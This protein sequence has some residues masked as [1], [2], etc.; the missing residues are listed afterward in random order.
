MPAKEDWPTQE[1]ADMLGPC[2]V[3][4]FR[5]LV[6]LGCDPGYLNFSL[7]F[8][9]SD[10]VELPETEFDPN[11]QESKVTGETRRFHLHPLDSWET[12]TARMNLEDLRQV[13]K[14]AKYLAE[15]IQGLRKTPLVAVLRRDGVLRRG[16]LLGGSPLVDTTWRLQGLIDLP[17]IAKER[18]SR[19]R[20]DRNE[21][22]VNLA[23]HIHEKTGD[24]QDKLRADLL[25]FHSNADRPG[26]A[27]GEEQWRKR[28][29][30]TS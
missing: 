12:A 13:A 10:R 8:L 5:D 7:S 24:W 20:P 22:R 4:A 25:A 23:R 27:K 17:D 14:R 28:R 16:D 9:G 11:S 15:E 18:I 30:L 26:S 29:N 19:K 2:G 1:V 21:V 6:C 3:R